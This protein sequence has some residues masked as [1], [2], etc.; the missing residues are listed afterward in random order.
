ML[1]DIKFCGERAAEKNAFF[2]NLQKQDQ[3][4]GWIEKSSQIYQGLKGGWVAIPGDP[5][6]SEEEFWEKYKMELRVARSS[7][8]FRLIRAFEG[9]FAT[10]LREPLK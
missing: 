6:I 5:A 7:K 1:L 8:I 10:F 4:N 2:G 3:P 9:R